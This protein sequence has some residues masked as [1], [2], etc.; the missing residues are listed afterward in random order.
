MSKARTFSTM[1]TLCTMLL[2]SDS[3][4]SCGSSCRFCVRVNPV[5]MVDGFLG[6]VVCRL[7]STS[8]LVG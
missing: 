1:S 2:R 7:Q 6:F 8:V 3:G 4:I 5:V